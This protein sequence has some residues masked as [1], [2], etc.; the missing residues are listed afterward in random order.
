[1]VSDVSKMNIFELRE[2]VKFY[3]SQKK[4]AAV[5]GVNQS[6]I[7]RYLSGDR[8]P[9]KE[10]VSFIRKTF[11]SKVK[12]KKKKNNVFSHKV[13][14]G[15]HFDGRKFVRFDFSLWRRN[16]SDPTLLPLLFKKFISLYDSVKSES[17][18]IKAQRLGV[19]ISTESKVTGLKS[20]FS[21]KAK[22]KYSRKKEN[23]DFITTIIYAR[24]EPSKKLMFDDLLQKIKKYLLGTLES[25]SLHSDSEVSREAKTFFVF[26]ED[27]SV[28][29]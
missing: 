12:K 22:R 1:M 4:L 15:T 28:D 20:Y 10:I 9:R 29:Y 23:L 7:S 17:P 6:Q 11:V 8:S 19:A 3:G 25:S 2:L 26:F 18:G 21:K 27:E 13:L 16:I 14:R 5:V 24:N